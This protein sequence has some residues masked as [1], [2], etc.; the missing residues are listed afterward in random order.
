MNQQDQARNRTVDDG[1]TAPVISL[2][3]VTRDFFDGK[4]NRTV[5]Q[6][7]DLEIMPGEL[8][9]LAG[10]SGS[11]KTTL[12]TIMGLVL[13]P[14]TGSVHI[15]SQDVTGLSEDERAVIRLERFGFVFQQAALVPALS[16]MENLLVSKTIQG[17][18]ATRGMKDEAMDLLTDL[19]LD[20]YA[21]ARPQ[22]L[23]TG[24]QQ[25]VGIA[26][27]LMGHP[28]LL[29]CDEPTSALDVES[30]R[31]VLDTLK[32]IST[33]KDRGIVLVSHDPRVFPYA[34]RLIKIEDGR[35]EQD[36]RGEFEEEEK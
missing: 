25:R 7:T 24:Q 26:R 28:L 17:R 19:G 36:T 22:Q 6:N 11:G 20:E 3:G 12:L 16:V 31:I 4:Q 2:K 14:T 27:A 21:D 15:R 34:D 30:S 18:R 32:Q 33:D 1:I 29:L 9:V 23:S 13:K 8:T 5:L 35:I 10:P